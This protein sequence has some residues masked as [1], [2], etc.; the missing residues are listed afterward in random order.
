MRIAVDAM[1][2]D[3]AP[4]ATVR[5]ALLAAG[6]NPE[7][8][9]LLVGVEN[10]IRSEIDAAGWG[11]A[12]PSSIEIVPAS[13][14]VGMGESPVEA[15]R[16]KKDTSIVK[17]ARLVERGEARAVVSAG[18]TGATVAAA[19]L[20]LGLLKGIRRP[21]IAVSLPAVRGVTTIIDVGAN[22]QCKPIH[23]LQYGVMASAY[24]QYM[25]RHPDPKVGLL[26]VGAETQK[27]TNLVRKTEHLFHESSLHFVGN[28]EGLEVFKGHCQVFVCDGFTGNLILKV[29]EGVAVG[30]VE[31]MRERLRKEGA[32]SS[33]LGLPLLGKVRKWF[34]SKLLG[35]A[36]SVVDYSEYGGAPLL[37]V[38]GVCIIAHGRS[39]AKAVASAIR[40]AREFS[41][42]NVNGHILEQLEPLCRI[43]STSTQ[44][45]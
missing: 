41:L 31:L 3:K 19:T 29:S 12:S 44:A 13:E 33:F 17:A 45:R 38:D 21:G 7:L 22:L 37:G 16:R 34:F 20:S 9:L 1:G 42:H 39:D 14:S 6:R 10:V 40:A 5:G 27:G 28:V 35:R 11:Q 32:G 36:R 2:G 30:L 25:F 15:L 43:D 24:H 8:R 23:L 26:N 18:N 4:A